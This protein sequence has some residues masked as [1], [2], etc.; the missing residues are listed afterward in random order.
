M[1]YLKNFFDSDPNDQRKFRLKT[2]LQQCPNCNGKGVCGFCAGSGVVAH[3]CDCEFCDVDEELC[4][5]CD[6]EGK[7]LRCDGTGFAMLNEAELRQAGLTKSEA[8]N[9]L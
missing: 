8:R 5:E 1:I 4:N 3:E 2:E 6:D 9:G 7:C